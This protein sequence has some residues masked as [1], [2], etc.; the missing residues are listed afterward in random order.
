MPYTNR[1][2]ITFWRWTAV[3]CLIL[4]IRAGQ[5]ASLTE[6][7]VLVSHLSQ[8]SVAG[9]ITFTQ[10]RPGEPV[11]IKAELKGAREYKG[12]YSWGIY[13][14]PIDYTQE[15]FCHSRLL[16]R[17]PILNFDTSLNKLPLDEAE[18]SEE[19]IISVSLEYTSSE[20]NLT[21]SGA[22]WGRGLVLEGPSRSRTCGSLMPASKSAKLRSAEARFTSPVAGSVWF[23]SYSNPNGNDTA[24]ETNIFTNLV[25]VTGDSKS[26]SHRWQ[27]FIT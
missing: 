9:T 16:G 10:L 3:L 23:S 22:V 18:A 21:G 14:F 19:A 1:T 24:A 2:L 5:V 8:H 20:L 27:L 13:E 17:K 25:H 15:D 7:T 6:A 26:S 11:S 12:E 4:V